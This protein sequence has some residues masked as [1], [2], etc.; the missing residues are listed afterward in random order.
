MPILLETLIAVSLQLKP[1]SPN[2]QKVTA[3]VVEP[4]VSKP[5]VTETQITK[6]PVVYENHRFPWGWC[7]Y[8]VSTKRNIPW[9]GNANQWP[10]RASTMGYEVS[11]SPKAGAVMVTN[12]SY[13]G[14]VAFVE[15]ID[16]TQFVVSEMNYVGF[17]KISYRTLPIKFRAQ[18]IY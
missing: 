14:H 2:P 7:T 8:Y 5:L 15:R 1:Y 13:I 16:E 12:E 4:Y 11:S 18:F 3:E 10:L 17:G 9:G 6:E